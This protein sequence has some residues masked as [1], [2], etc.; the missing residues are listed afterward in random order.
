M[1]RH[2]HQHHPPVTLDAIAAIRYVFIRPPSPSVYRSLLSAR[3]PSHPLPSP[4]FVPRYYV[5]RIVS[6]IEGMKV[7]LLD[8]ETTQIVSTV[9]SQVGRK[10]G[11]EGGRVDG[12]MK[13]ARAFPHSLRDILRL[14]R[15]YRGF[16]IPLFSTPPSS[17]L[18]FPPLSV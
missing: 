12:E 4:L 8:E 7:L 14:R 15:R 3:V 18:T 17:S 11:R 9:Y 1:T 10:R 6:S 16:A 5:D 2:V 13:N